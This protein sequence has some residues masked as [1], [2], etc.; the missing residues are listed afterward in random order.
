M[1]NSKHIFIQIDT[2][3]II[4]QY[5]QNGAQHLTS[6]QVLAHTII[7]DRGLIGYGDA[8]EQFT[9]YGSSYQEIHFTILPVKLY[10]ENKLSFVNF[11]NGTKIHGITIDDHVFPNSSDNM[12]RISFKISIEKNFRGANFSLNG[13]LEYG[14]DNKIPFVIDPM[15]QVVQPGG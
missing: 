3:G 1:G 14:S 2:D 13:L 11:N 12:K 6:D 5:I 15:I 9:I 8:I 10:S 4:Q 7:Y